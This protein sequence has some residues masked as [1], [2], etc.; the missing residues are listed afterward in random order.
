MPIPPPSTDRAAIAKTKI[1]SALRRWMN[2]DVLTLSERNLVALADSANRAT[3][4][5]REL[6]A[7]AGRSH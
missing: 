1:A 6:D 5:E 4:C 3:L 7:L 2:G